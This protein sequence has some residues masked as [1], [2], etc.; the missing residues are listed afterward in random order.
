[1]KRR[2]FIQSLL[3]LLL[4]PITAIAAA[5]NKSAFEAQKLEEAQHNLAV[6]AEVQSQEIEIVAP[7]RAENG[8]V[9]QIE[10]NCRIP[11][12]EAIAIF[13]AENPTPLIANYML[14]AGT[15]SHVVTRI[16][17]AQ[18]SE[19]KAVVKV[20]ERYFFNSK[21]V[22]VLED[23]CGGS[24]SDGKFESSM[25]MRAKLVGEQVEVKVII[26]H[27]M[28]TGRS[29]NSAGDIIP[30]HFIQVLQARLNGKPVLEAHYGTAIAKNPYLTFY[31]NGATVG[32][33]VDVS[34]VDNQGNR[35]Q[36]EILV[37]L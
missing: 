20:G 17:M 28:T 22:V 4:T 11:N 19:V 14:G 18:T 21:Q 31:L 10:V 16:K 26:V 32:D 25:K 2:V 15:Q 9:V 13:V 29:K 6:N 33:K 34:W 5:W 23:G 27:P 30:A 37:S 7:D 12:A 36:G 3:G 8:A 1:M 24:D 35:G